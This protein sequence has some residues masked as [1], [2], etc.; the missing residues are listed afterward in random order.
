MEPAFRIPIASGIADSLRCIFRIPKI[1]I[2]DSTTKICWIPDSTS[3]NFPDFGIWNPLLGGEVTL[4]DNLR[5]KQEYLLYSK[6][7]STIWT[8]HRKIFWKK[9]LILENDL[10]IK[11]R[12]SEVLS[13]LKAKPSGHPLPICTKFGRFIHF[14]KMASAS[15][16]HW[17]VEEA[18]VAKTWE[19]SL[20]VPTIWW[21]GFSIQ[22][23]KV[24]RK[25]CALL[26]NL[27]L[28]KS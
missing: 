8:L 27:E 14:L 20:S 25:I 24:L 6:L 15:A 1:R 21:H 16:L 22:R 19:M 4:S 3:Q 18:G 2:P 23:Y 26:H 11:S 12:I 9:L 5:T 17:S 7:S 28:A 10:V 13:Q